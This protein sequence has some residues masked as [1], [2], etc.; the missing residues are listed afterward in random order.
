L[1]RS[2][3]RNVTIALLLAASTR[4]AISQN[5]TA[6]DIEDAD[7]AAANSEIISKAG[8]SVTKTGFGSAD[9]VIDPG[10]M[11][12]FR[13]EGLL[14]RTVLDHMTPTNVVNVEGKLDA[15]A[16]GFIASFGASGDV[17]QVN[18]GDRYYL[19]EATLQDNAILF[20]F[21]SVN[22]TELVVKGQSARSR[23]RMY[24]K[25][26]LPKVKGTRPALSPEQIHAMTDPVFV[27][28]GSAES[29]PAI[30][31]GEVEADVRKAL[32]EPDKALRFDNKTILVYK[33]IKI[34]L[35]DGKV[36]SVD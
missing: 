8:Y 1:S 24:V 35:A 12:A 29:M 36:T 19:H 7:K 18:P 31:S 5:N 3:L 27:P 23:L 6:Q 16:K 21:L 30:L 11:Y 9:R 22:T 32:G 20:T 17:Q 2:F 25:F 34:V 13:I 28:A 15:P 10:T 33:G 14:S 26:Q 4:F